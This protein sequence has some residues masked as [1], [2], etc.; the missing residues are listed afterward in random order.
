MESGQFRGYDF[1]LI[2]YPSKA[3]LSPP[4]ALPI[5][6]SIMKENNGISTMFTQFNINNLNLLGIAILDLIKNVCIEENI[7]S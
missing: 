2:I 3:E 6:T 7:H 5:N 1:Q 4:K